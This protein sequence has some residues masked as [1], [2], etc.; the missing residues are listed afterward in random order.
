MS[1]WTETSILIYSAPDFSVQIKMLEE[2]I[3]FPLIWISVGLKITKPTISG[4]LTEIRLT[5]ALTLKIFVLFNGT[6]I[7]S[8]V[9][10][11][12]IDKDGMSGAFFLEAATA[13]AGVITKCIL[14]AKAIIFKGA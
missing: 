9:L 6:S 11:S 7:Y 10:P 8:C 13:Q 1:R 4:L 5:G 2:P 14:N 12:V 3:C